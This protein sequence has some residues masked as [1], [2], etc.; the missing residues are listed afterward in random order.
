MAPVQM[1]DSYSY[2]DI[3]KRLD[4]P[5]N[6]ADGLAGKLLINGAAGFVGL[7]QIADMPIEDIETEL[8]FLH[9]KRASCVEVR[10]AVLLNLF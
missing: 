4:L 3:G 8:N 7:I 2:D 6:P 5:R 9:S 10:L 1:P